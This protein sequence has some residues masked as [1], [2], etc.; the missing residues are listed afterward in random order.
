MESVP[1]DPTLSSEDGTGY[2]I[3][4]TASGRLTVCSA[5][6][7]DGATTITVTR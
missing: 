7:T 6:E 1:T 5:P 3:A 4:K 2:Y